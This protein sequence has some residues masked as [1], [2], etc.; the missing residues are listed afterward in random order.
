MESVSILTICADFLSEKKNSLIK[1]HVAVLSQISMTVGLICC[2]RFRVHYD[3][4]DFPV[5]WLGV[6]KKLSP[7]KTF[8][9]V[10]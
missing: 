4:H 1:V 9:D 6:A 3:K 5:A 10:L 2:S 8:Q 7:T